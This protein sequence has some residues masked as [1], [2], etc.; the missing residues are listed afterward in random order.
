MKRNL[1]HF[2]VY[3]K[4]RAKVLTAFLALMLFTAMSFAQTTVYF[5]NDAGWADV[6][7]HHFTGCTAGEST[8]PGI[9]GTNI[10]GDLWEFTV[11]DGCME[12]IFNN[13]NNGSQTGTLA[14]T[15]DAYYNATEPD[16]LGIEEMTYLSPFV[17]S[18]VPSCDDGGDSAG[19]WRNGGII[20]DDPVN[21]DF[22]INFDV[23]GPHTFCGCGQGSIARVILRRTSG[24]SEPESVIATEE[25]I[26][27][28]ATFDTSVDTGC[29][30]GKLGNNDLYFVN[31]KGTG[32]TEGRWSI[33]VQTDIPGGDYSTTS[34]LASWTYT[35]NTLTGGCATQAVFA[36]Y[37]QRST[38]AP[39]G[40]FGNTMPSW[41]DITCAVDDPLDDIKSKVG[42]C[43]ALVNEPQLEYIT[44]GD[45]GVY[46][47]MAVFGNGTSDVFYDMG[48]FQPG[49]PT[50]PASLNGVRIPV[51]CPNEEILTTSSTGI[52]TGDTDA[53][54]WLGAETNTWKRLTVGGSSCSANVTGSTL[55]YRVYA[56]GAAAPAFAPLVL[57]FRDDCPLGIV[58]P[59]TNVG[60]GGNTFPDGGSCGNHDCYLDQRWQKY[61]TGSGAT[62]GGAH[63]VGP[64]ASGAIIENIAANAGNYIIEMYTE[65][66]TTD[67]SGASVTAREPLTGEYVTSFTI[68]DGTENN[69]IC[70]VAATCNSGGTSIA[71]QSFESSASDSWNYT[72][73]QTCNTNGDEFDVFAAPYGSSAIP[74]S[75]GSN[76]F[77]M[78][79]VDGC[80]NGVSLDT[81]Y[82]AA[83][84]I[85]AGVTQV[86]ICADSYHNGA[87]DVTSGADEMFF[88]IF[89]D[90]GATTTSQGILDAESCSLDQW[91][92][93]CKVVDVQPGDQISMTF[94]GGND[95][96]TEE[97]AIDNISICSY[98]ASSCPKPDIIFN[99]IAADTG[100]GDSDGGEWVELFCR[101]GPCDISGF[102]L[103][104]GELFI[105]IPA[106]TTLATGDYYT[107]GHQYL[108][109]GDGS[110]NFDL[111]ANGGHIHSLDVGAPTTTTCGVTSPICAL[112]DEP[113]FTLDN[114][115]EQIALYN[116]CDFADPVAAVSWGTGQGIPG[117]FHC[118]DLGITG[119]SMPAATD[120][121]WDYNF[122]INR[123]GCTTSYAYDSATDSWRE[124][125]TPTPGEINTA[126]AYTLTI[127]YVDED[128]L[129][130][131]ATFNIG[132][133]NT[134]SQEQSA[135][136]TALGTLTICDE[137]EISVSF[138][139]I[140]HQTLAPNE[141]VGGGGAWGPMADGWGSGIAYSS[142]LSS[143]A[144]AAGYTATISESGTLY[145]RIRELGYQSNGPG[146]TFNADNGDCEGYPNSTTTDNGMSTDCIIDLNIPITV[147]GTC[148]V[149]VEL[150]NFTAALNERVV[151][152]NWLTV[153]ETN[154]SHFLVQ[155]S[156]DGQRFETLGK[157]DA[158]GFS[159][160]ELAY[161]F[162]DATIDMRIP[163]YYYR[164]KMVDLDGTFEYSRSIPVVINS[165]M[166]TVELSP[167]PTSDVITLVKYNFVGDVNIS[168]FNSVGALVARTRFADDLNV[169]EIDMSQFAKGMYLIN[170][171]DGTNSV[172]EKVIVE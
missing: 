112:P 99:E 114:G 83:V 62:A 97:S 108:S 139:Q 95:A 127:E 161:S 71:A 45:A 94:T 123:S 65:T 36:P 154:S 29:G 47:T 111:T 2:K 33:E 24:T 6:R 145:I 54:L 8:W 66:Y 90:D 118:C 77:G 153:A 42:I 32:I 4:E 137:S 144:L 10:C 64:T 61:Q 96:G 100:S 103:T 92:T 27:I 17:T 75:D 120:A 16:P 170:L 146:T 40:Q 132:S 81:I 51:S 160:Q 98:D 129:T 72:V 50:L 151:D 115:N 130:Q 82:F 21:E 143:V 88:E 93:Y 63:I 147:S 52:C 46:R 119:I 106:G 140:D 89:L 109:T 163:R 74:A 84:T 69:G 30:P 113:D 104:D 26:V 79:D 41:Y 107:V 155:R 162:E 117:T 57:G 68:V 141:V 148:I 34:A 48:K 87:Y 7:M 126:L 28:D 58:A 15:A 25:A 136:E 38:Q 91:T 164:L 149:P 39:T 135:I 125:D 172:V 18:Y 23:A 165:K 5:H 157:V 53:E 67:C 76:V 44:V 134:L 35:E 86:E 150:L 1:T 158:A 9:T 73:L 156:K 37:Y 11:P 22:Y 101:T 56:A 14:V 31:L 169:K 105:E 166:P 78:S 102:I 133:L 12:I 122:N 131:T 70:S 124:D 128:E 159:T 49:N 60:P 152:L 85:P 121:Y 116:P 55:F 110:P 171:S 167:N 43:D 142:D 168:I 13:N 20:Y 3:F 19:D 138:S 80:R 59:G